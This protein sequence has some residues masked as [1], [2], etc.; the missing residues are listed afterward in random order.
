MH[1]PGYNGIIFRRTY[2]ELV[3]GGSIWEESHEIYPL[4]GGK[5]TENDLTWNFPSGAIIKFSHLQHPKDVYAHQGKQYAFC[6]HD[7]ITHFEAIQF[8]YLVSRMRSTYG[9]VPYMRATT[10]PDPDS[11]V[12][13]FIEW[14]IGKDGFAIPERSGKL[15]WFVREG[16]AIEWGDTKQEMIDRFPGRNPMSA[17]FIPAKL[18]D[19]PALTEKDPGYRDRLEA[20][21]RVQRERLLGGNWNVKESA[22]GL[23]RREWFEVVD[24]APITPEVRARA[25]DKAA[26]KPSPQN[27]D[28]DWTAGVLMSRA[29]DGT[30]FIEHVY[31]LRDNPAGVEAALRNIT[32]QDGQ[33]VISA[34][35][36]DPGQ[37]GKVEIEH[38][39][40]VI[41]THRIK[42]ERASKNKI[43]Y[44]EPVSALAENGK[45]KVVR[46]Q[47]NDAFFSELE[48]FPDG[49]HDDQVDALSLA[50]LACGDDPLMHLRM[51]TKA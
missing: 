5:A 50:Y 4:L 45:I 22:G 41:P 19:N 17:T 23:F 31:R 1:V 35:W 9:V 29:K 15:R 24:R 20:L 51:M 38:V 3:G 27:P 2:P 12:R 7:E 16:D 11:W 43:S 36:Q 46:G 47:W 25:W 18:E 14:W 49:G 40:Q 34:H 10:N 26:T 6:G 33:H 8:W 42:I 28:P 37:A 32:S 13:K 48:S 21:P 44:A 39:K 30:F